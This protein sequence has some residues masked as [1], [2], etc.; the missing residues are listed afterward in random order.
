MN[1]NTY[2]KR[3]KYKQTQV[4]ELF[5]HQRFERNSRSGRRT[6]N[7]MATTKRSVGNSFFKQTVRKNKKNL[8]TIFTRILKSKP[9]TNRSR[10]NL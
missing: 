2:T 1:T 9:K 8:P 6:R 7:K 3:K 4:K 10:I 5:F